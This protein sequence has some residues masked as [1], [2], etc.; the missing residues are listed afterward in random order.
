MDFMEFN[1]KDINFPTQSTSVLD[2][3][4]IFDL[5]CIQLV[6][7]VGLQPCDS[8]SLTFDFTCSFNQRRSELSFLSK[9]SQQRVSVT[10]AI[11][12]QG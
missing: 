12:L 1:S 9:Q 10:Q 8:G 3:G 11:T 4:F 5:Q 6:I 2:E 7:S